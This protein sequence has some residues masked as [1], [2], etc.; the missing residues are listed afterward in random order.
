MAEVTGRS[1][2]LAFQGPEVQRQA[3]AAWRAAAHSEAPGLPGPATPAAILAMLLKEAAG[4]RVRMMVA[5]PRVRMMVA[6]PRVR[7]VVAGLRL[8]MAV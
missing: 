8:R 7:I 5:G 3:L 1:E 6:G 2:P 4:P